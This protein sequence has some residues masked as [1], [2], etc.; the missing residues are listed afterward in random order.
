MDGVKTLVYSPT[1]AAPGNYRRVERVAVGVCPP[2]SFSKVCA[3][4]RGVADDADLVGGVVIA[5][6]GLK[7]VEVAYDT[8]W[9]LLESWRLASLRK[10]SRKNGAVHAASEARRHPGECITDLHHRRHRRGDRCCAIS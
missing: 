3:L 1:E 8:I 4:L 9:E 5:D 2:K 6:V 10:D 7:G